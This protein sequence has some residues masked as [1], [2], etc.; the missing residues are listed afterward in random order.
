MGTSAYETGNL[1][2]VARF[3]NL[4]ETV[5]IRVPTVS[6]TL[7]KTITRDDSNRLLDWDLTT[8]YDLPIASGIYLIHVAVPGVGER[9]LKFGVVHRRPHISVF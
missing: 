6:G 8:D 2:R 3:T 1:N 4:P 7:V 9:V 5:S